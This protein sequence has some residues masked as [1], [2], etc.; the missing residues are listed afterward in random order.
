M[1]NAL[2]SKKPDKKLTEKFADGK[3]QKFLRISGKSRL[4]S[5]TTSLF[6]SLQISCV[7]LASAVLN[8]DIRAVVVVLFLLLLFATESRK[9]GLKIEI[10]IIPSHSPQWRSHN[11]S[12]GTAR[13]EGERFIADIGLLT[14][15]NWE[16]DLACEASEKIVSVA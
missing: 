15:L 9:A 1:V 3:A 16:Y 6:L 7:S 2:A 8:C 4:L 5:Q 13:Q 14:V 11:F 10:E 12:M